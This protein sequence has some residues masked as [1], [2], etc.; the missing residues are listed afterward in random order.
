MNK[1]SPAVHFLDQGQLCCIGVP[2]STSG[3][4]DTCVRCEDMR[5]SAL[6][7]GG[8]ELYGDGVSTVREAS[9]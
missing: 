3:Y 9:G 4:G 2:L 7:Y 5:G 1:R 6:A 8:H